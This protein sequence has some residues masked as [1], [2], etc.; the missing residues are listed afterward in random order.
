[1]APYSVSFGSPKAPGT[2]LA[3]GTGLKPWFDD[4]LFCDVDL[5]PLLFEVCRPIKPS[6]CVKQ[7]FQ[8]RQVFI[9]NK[10]DHLRHILFAKLMPGAKAR[11]R[12]TRYPNSR[13]A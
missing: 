9:H 10:G 6:L 4:A 5:T 2:G 3:A 1:M 11:A 8:H 12:L 7:C 13:T